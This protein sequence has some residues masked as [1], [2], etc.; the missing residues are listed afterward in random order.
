MTNDTFSA[1]LN[2][3]TL[4]TQSSTLPPS[5]ILQLRLRFLSIGPTVDPSLQYVWL[6]LYPKPK[7]CISPLYEA[8]PPLLFHPTSP[9]FT[10]HI[11]IS[12]LNSLAHLFNH[13]SDIYS[14]WPM[15]IGVD[16]SPPF[17]S[18]GAFDLGLLSNAPLNQCTMCVHIL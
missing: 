10:S 5:P 6:N 16:P 12:C 17:F 9:Q 8:D 1:G 18:R 14:G 7:P 2:L 13:V 4:L 3:T 15:A 11:R